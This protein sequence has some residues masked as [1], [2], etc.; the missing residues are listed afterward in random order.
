M[1]ILWL[2]SAGRFHLANGIRRADGIEPADPQQ[3]PGDNENL[4]AGE[5]AVN[6]PVAAAAALCLLAAARS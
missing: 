6:K 1:L 5:P 4:P 3:N 2:A